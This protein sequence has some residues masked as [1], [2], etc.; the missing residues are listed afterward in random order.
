MFSEMMI[1]SSTMMPIIRMTEVS[2]RISRKAPKRGSRKK[3]PRIE[4]GIPMATQK[5]VLP[6][7][8]WYK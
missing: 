6:E 5:A 1:P 7:V 8:M 2:E 3:T 4:T